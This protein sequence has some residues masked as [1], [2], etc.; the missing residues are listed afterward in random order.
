[1]NKFYSATIGIFI[2]LGMAV[3][4]IGGGFSAESAGGDKWNNYN[5]FEWTDVFAMG[6]PGRDLYQLIY[7]KL[8]YYPDKN[9]TKVVAQNNGLSVEE[10]DMAIK[11][12]SY[13]IINNPAAN[14]NNNLSLS[15]GYRKLQGIQDEYSELKTLFEL[16]QNI[17]VQTVMG[18]IFANGDLSDSGFDLV[19][20]LSLIEDIIFKEK[21][22]SEFGGKFAKSVDF[23]EAEVN[24]PAETSL[25]TPKKA[26]AIGSLSNSQGGL[27][28][29][30]DGG[31]NLNIGDEKVN[32]S[33][34]EEDFCPVDEDISN[35]LKDFENDDGQGANNNQ[36]GG[37]DLLLAD[38]VN[39]KEKQA[40]LKDE[41]GYNIPAE[42]ELPPGFFVCEPSDGSSTQSGPAAA[43]SFNSLGDGAFSGFWGDVFDG[44]VGALFGESGTGSFSEGFGGSSGIKVPGFAAKVSLCFDIELVW[45]RAYAVKNQSCI[46]CEVEK[47]NKYLNETLSHSL[48][49]NKVTGNL[50]ESAKCKDA[51]T[52]LLDMNFIALSKPIPSPPND[53]L[54]SKVDIVERWNKFVESYSPLL[55]SKIDEKT[56]FFIENADQYV[57]QRDF[58]AEVYRELTVESAKAE[59]ALDKTILQEGNANNLIYTQEV[60]R[61]LKQM[62]AFF[63]NYN[64][65]FN[66]SEKVCRNILK[67]PDF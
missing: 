1:M 53:D 21:T 47:I 24:V 48:M 29:N 9:A 36:E 4:I 13:V 56:D 34:K 51:F 43:F 54:L 8:V 63:E 60:L 5:L 12:S 30:P 27:E 3:S 52:P 11:G 15:E 62:S 46:A 18:E 23:S 37:E 17:E 64:K 61:E 44:N 55:T 25:G 26:D 32:V 35:A 41:F 50:M 22:T 58:N 45:K 42:S 10:A 20:D 40:P 66:D 2:G 67:K 28:Q 16:E 39:T 31:L 57:S 19:H 14:K 59:A 6:D 38:D 49:P 65:I 33:L 7:N